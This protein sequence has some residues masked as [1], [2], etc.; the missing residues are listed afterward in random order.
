MKKLKYLIF[1]LLLTFVGMSGIKAAPADF[2]NVKLK[3]EGINEYSQ[4]SAYIRIYDAVLDETKDDYAALITKDNTNIPDSIEDGFSLEYYSSIQ[5]LYIDEDTTIKNAAIDSTDYQKAAEKFG[6]VYVTF[7]EHESGSKYNKISETI[8]V[9]KPANL[10]LS[11]RVKIY[12]FEDSTSFY[13]QTINNISTKRQITYK[14]GEVTDKTILQKIKNGSYAGL[15]ELLAFGKKDTKAVSTNTVE[16]KSGLPAAFEQS[17]LIE[18]HYYYAYLEVDSE[19]GAYLPVEDVNLYQALKTNGELWLCDV[20]D[21]NFVWNLEETEWEKFVK[22]FMENEML[23]L[24]E[25]GALNIEYDSEKM[26]VTITDGEDKYITQFNYDNGIVSY[27][28]SDTKTEGELFTDS[29]MQSIVLQE[30]AKRFNYDL[31][32]MSKYLE[33]NQNLTVE[34]NGIEYELAKFNISESDGAASGT[35]SG[36]YFKTLKFDLINGLLNYTEKDVEPT[37]KNPVTGLYVGLGVVGFIS[38]LSAGLYL[39]MRKKNVF[40]KA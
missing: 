23:D 5:D 4:G 20:N 2:S 21:D 27:E 19:N 32:K 9:E 18:G 11:K 17:D 36:E 40:P 6:N 28:Y 3:V 10:K 25:E 26:V 35:I 16:L 15:E 12:L 22:N 14:I 34:K 30:F 31:E 38:V 29:I 7:Y 8:L 1:T 33:A 13:L 24:Y 39:L 37:V